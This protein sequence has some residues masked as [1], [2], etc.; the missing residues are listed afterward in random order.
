MRPYRLRMRLSSRRLN[1][2][3]FGWGPGAAV[4]AAARF[5][6]GSASSDIELMKRLLSSKVYDCANRRT[7]Q[8]AL[9]KYRRRRSRL[10]AETWG[11]GIVSGIIFL[12][13]F[14]PSTAPLPCEKK[15]LRWPGPFGSGFLSPQPPGAVG[16]GPVRRGANPHTGPTRVGP[17]L[18]GGC[19][20]ACASDAPVKDGDR[21]SG[22]CAARAMMC[23][24]TS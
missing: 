13:H 19:L 3:R 22:A 17:F 11:H 2:T 5:S 16:I 18:F 23:N 8:E 4:R 9:C 12:P 14:R 21:H 7:L 15:I 10:S 24:C 20:I 1:V 6:L